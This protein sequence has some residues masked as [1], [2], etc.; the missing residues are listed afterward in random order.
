MNNPII[1]LL[2]KYERYEIFAINSCSLS[3][4]M[5]LYEY[6]KRCSYHLEFIAILFNQNFHK[7]PVNKFYELL[8]APMPIQYLTETLPHDDEVSSRVTLNTM[9]I[10]KNGNCHPIIQ[11]D[12]FIRNHVEPF[13]KSLSSS[14]HKDGDETEFIVP[15]NT[16]TMAIYKNGNNYSIIKIDMFIWNHVEPFAIYPSYR[17]DRDKIELIGILIDKTFITLTINDLKKCITLPLS[18]DM[19]WHTLIL[20][21]YTKPS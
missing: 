12:R 16:N 17:K 18:V 11:I 9:I 5:A 19:E 13:A 20:K 2:F 3:C 1:A 4:A 8:H 15:I 6:N 14:P 10:C 21:K 7:L